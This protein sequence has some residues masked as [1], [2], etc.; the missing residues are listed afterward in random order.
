MDLLLGEIDTR[1]GIILIT[2]EGYKL[3]CILRLAFKVTNNVAE[4]EALLAGLQSVK[5]KHAQ[6]IE[7]KNDF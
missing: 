1:A 2:P 5:E 7:M 6:K 3:N 4:Y